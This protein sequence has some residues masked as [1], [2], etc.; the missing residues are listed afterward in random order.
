MWTFVSRVMSLLFNTL[1]RFVTAFLPNRL[2]ENIDY[3]F[4]YYI[5]GPCWLSILYIWCCYSVVKSCPTLQLHGLQHARLLCPLPSP[6]VYPSLCPLHHWCHPTV[7]SSITLFSFS[8]QSFPAAGSSPMTLCIRWPK[9]WSFSFSN[10]S[11]QW[12]LKVEFL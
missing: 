7:S 9:Y 3:T 10:Q 4:L 2:L 1:S 5:V 11:Y 12:V 8:L 6:R